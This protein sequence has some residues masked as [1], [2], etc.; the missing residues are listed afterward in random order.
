MKKWHIITLAI[1]GTLFI[2]YQF[3]A[4]TGFLAIFKNST[5]TNEPNINEGEIIITT[6][7]LKPKQGDFV[8]YRYRYPDSLEYHY[9]IHRLVAVENDVLEIKDGVLFINGK[10][11]DQD[12]SLTH[13]YKISIEEFEK[14]DVLRREIGENYRWM[15]PQDTITKFIDDRVAEKLKLKKRK[16]VEPIGELDQNI[17]AIYGQNWNKDNF[18]PFKIPSG[19]VFVLGDN[20]HQSE[21]SRYLGPI[22]SSNIKGVLIKPYVQIN[23]SK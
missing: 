3:L 20:R 11:F 8:S 5:W 6:N 15:K 4:L 17:K 23:D 16:V 7:L 1:I 13:E 2:I 12:Y 14:F 19:K 22:Q 9:R 18:G 10:N 21:D